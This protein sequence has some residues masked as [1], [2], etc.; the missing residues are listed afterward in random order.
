MCGA[1]FY[2]VFYSH[3]IPVIVI[4]YEINC[5]EAPN[6]LCKY[7]FPNVLSIPH[8]N[9][10]GAMPNISIAEGIDINWGNAFIPDLWLMDHP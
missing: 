6:S 3:V 5:E 10:Q 2:P 1:N 9:P 8:N 4:L 7:K